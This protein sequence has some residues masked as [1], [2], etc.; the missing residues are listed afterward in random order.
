MA[1]IISQ[2]S[3]RYKEGSESLVDAA[4][5]KLH[6]SH[7]SIVRSAVAKVSLD[8]RKNDAITFVGSVYFELLSKSDEEQLCEK[9]SDCRMVSKTEPVF[10]KGSTKPNGRIV[11]AG[12]GPAGMFCALMLARMGYKPLVIE[13]GD[14]IEERVKKVEQ[15]WKG[16]CL[17]TETNVQFGEGGAGTFSDGKLTTRINDDFCNSVL[18]IFSEAGAPEEI[19]TKSKPHIGTDKLRDVVKNIRAEIVRN[20]GEVRFNT[21]LD[22][23]TMTDG[24]V[25]AVKFGGSDIKTAALVLAIGHSARDTFEMLLKKNIF[26]EPKAFSVGARIEHRRE[27]VNKSLYGRLFDDKSLPV[28]EYQLSYRNGN[29]CTYTF[30]MCPGGYVV[31]SSSEEG[32]VVVNGMSEFA[33]D[34]ENSNSAVAVSVS[35]DD[36]GN[37]PLDGVEFARSIEKKAYSAGGCCYKAPAVSVGNFMN[38]KGGIAAGSVIP[39]YSVG[40]KESD[41]ADVFPS[42]VNDALREGL[43]SFSHKMKCFGDGKAILTAA[44]TRTSSPVRIT[45]GENMQSVSLKGLYPAGE[46]AGYAGGIVSAAVDG[47]RIAQKIISEYSSD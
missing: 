17:D 35:P 37:N 9:Y 32:G 2:I 1:F 43:S 18:R 12:F 31:P 28:G 19:L 24:R 5:K 22:G 36:Y 26:I 3:I 40:V 41:F 33:R 16:G 4:V 8:A 14:C 25:T 15:F 6:L 27:E 29:R 7:T 42:F 10:E 34:G 30:C 39:S 38:N 21:K 23:I 11:V 47:L 13:R 20:G 44:E 45:R 46:G